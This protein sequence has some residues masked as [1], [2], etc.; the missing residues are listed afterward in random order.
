MPRD[1]T[2]GDGHTLAHRRVPLNIR[3]HFFTVRV[4]E[5]WDRLPR[6]VVGTPSLE[7]LKIC[8]DM[9]LGNCLYVALLEHDG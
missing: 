3:K 1:G 2:R 6:K 9:V 4:T 7:I 8:P 5:H